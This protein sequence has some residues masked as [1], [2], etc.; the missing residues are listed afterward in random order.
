VAKTDSALG[1]A[2]CWC[3]EMG[4]SLEEAEFEKPFEEGPNEQVVEDD[5]WLRF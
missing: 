1:T 4:P 2:G 5:D 3:E